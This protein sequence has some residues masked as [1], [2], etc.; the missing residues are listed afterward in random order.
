[1]KIEQLRQALHE[2]NSRL[3]FHL[4]VLRADNQERE[5]VKYRADVD[6]Q[7]GIIAQAEIALVRIQQERDLT[8]KRR[9]VAN[10]E[11]PNLQAEVSELRR[12]LT[13][14]EN[15]ETIER[16]LA[17]HREIENLNNQNETVR[18]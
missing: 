12:K 18:S 11:L 5:D 13:I 10:R 16:A 15:K 2:K 6:L 1:M 8:T 14:A 4:G 9:E 17:L 3:Q 7:K